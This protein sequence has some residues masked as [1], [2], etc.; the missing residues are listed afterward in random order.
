MTDRGG[1]YD[2]GRAPGAAWEQG[3]Y[4]TTSR[5]GRRM[6]SKVWRAN[7]DR[8]TASGTPFGPNPLPGGFDLRPIVVVD[9]I[10]GL[11]WKANTLY[12]SVESPQM[13]QANSWP[14]VKAW[15]ADPTGR[16]T[17]F[18]TVELRG[19]HG[20]G[21]WFR[22]FEIAPFQQVAIPVET[23]DDVNVSLI[24]SAAVNYDFVVVASE[25]VLQSNKPPL[26]FLPQTDTGG[27]GTF[28][29]PPGA[30]FLTPLQDAPDFVWRGQVDGVGSVIAVPLF[31]G[32]TVP[33][34]GGAYA[35]SLDP[36]RGTWSIS[37]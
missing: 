4:P 26:V 8:D 15:T 27:S 7:Y 29:T 31:K 19:Q 1:R 35:P 28:L 34:L 20:G 12:L 17:Q 13:N 37:F 5:G 33:V 21:F 9:G 10:A 11:N 14:T 18:M 6:R 25:H 16:T 23:L 30:S 36:F 32:V 22:R 24:S 3:D 2:F